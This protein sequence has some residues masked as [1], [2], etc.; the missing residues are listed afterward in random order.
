M[1]TKNPHR[2]YCKYY[3]L[4]LVPV[5]MELVKGLIIGIAALAKKVK[6]D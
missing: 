3:F 2:S 6:K 5:L 1:Q 4:E